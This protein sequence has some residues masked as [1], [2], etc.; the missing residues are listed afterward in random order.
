MAR[1]D[2]KES[3]SLMMISIAMLLLSVLGSAAGVTVGVVMSS[4]I[5]PDS[6]TNS[7]VDKLEEDTSKQA[8]VAQSST[9]MAGKEEDKVQPGGGTISKES[10]LVDLRVVPLPPVLTTLT[11]PKGTWIRLEGAALTLSRTDMEPELLAEKTGEQILSYLRT[12]RLA[13]L[14]TPSG[15][16]G[17]RDDLNENIKVM[18]GGQVRGI[19][20]HGLIV[21]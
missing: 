9:G 3:R 17:V 11:E 5:P 6:T 4:K 16:L 12:L 8:N 10:P 21:E 1:N 2:G 18:S 20:I 14:E 15:F 19:L 13:D 7:S